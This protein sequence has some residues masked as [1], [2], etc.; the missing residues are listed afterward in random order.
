[1]NISEFFRIT[2]NNIVQCVNYSDFENVKVS[3]IFG[4]RF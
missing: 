1:M 2:P 3:K 4:R